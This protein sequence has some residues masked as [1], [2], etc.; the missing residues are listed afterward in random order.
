MMSFGGRK[1]VNQMKMALLIKPGFKQFVLTPETDEEKAIF[2]M[3]PINE[4]VPFLVKRG[5]FY[6]ACAGGYHREFKCD[7]SLMFVFA[8]SNEMEE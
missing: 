8:A 6:A 7:D 5:S 3:V 2:K 1:E 4:Q